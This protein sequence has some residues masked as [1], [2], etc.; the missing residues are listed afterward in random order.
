MVNLE[1]YRTKIFPHFPSFCIVCKAYHYSNSLLKWISFKLLFYVSTENFVFNLIRITIIQHSGLWEL[2]YTEILIKWKRSVRIDWNF[3]HR[4]ILWFSIEL[5]T[6][7]KMLWSQPI[8]EYPFKI[9][10]IYDTF[11]NF[12]VPGENMRGCKWV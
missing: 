7:Q 11:E 2:K 6:K 1:W 10:S 4:F 5:G 12:Y 9:R 3:Q 8:S